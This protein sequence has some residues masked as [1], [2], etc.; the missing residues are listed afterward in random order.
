MVSNSFTLSDEATMNQ[1]SNEN[2][3]VSER[4]GLQLSKP[5][6]SIL[7]F[8]IA[9]SVVHK[10]S[11]SNEKLLVNSRGVKQIKNCSFACLFRRNLVY[12]N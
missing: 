4:R 1:I 11:G 10:G 3:L 5:Y 9:N 2:P 12:I 8:F 6:V 7:A